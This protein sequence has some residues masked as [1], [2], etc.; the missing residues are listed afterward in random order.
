MIRSPILAVLASLA[1]G[2]SVA[3]P[4]ASNV[5]PAPVTVLAPAGQ[6]SRFAALKVMV[7]PSQSVQ[8]DD[9]ASW[10]STATSDRSLL[11]A[12]DSVVEQALGARGLR[13]LWIFPAT[14]QKSAK[15][16]PT[17]LTDPYLMQALGPVRLSIKNP[18]DVLSEPFASQLR[19]LAGVNDSRYAWIPLV[20]RFEPFGPDG[21]ARAVLR[22]VVV[23]ARG[24]QVVWVGEVAG[25]P[26][27]Q[28]SAT[29]LTSLALRVAD[30][31]VP[32]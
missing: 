29:V 7:L 24:A 9:R 15:R 30:L 3:K 10:R 32:Q 27:P 2:G 18:Q 20:L 22:S 6:L 28:Y 21:N 31:V 26:Q 4:S 14:L 25:Q 16:N 19:A 8:A 1:C 12:L 17:Y 5:P 13:A 23:D 11:T